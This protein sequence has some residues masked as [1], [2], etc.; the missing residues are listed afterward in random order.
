MN[1]C[2]FLGHIFP[3]DP[4]QVISNFWVSLYALVKEGSWPKI[5][6][7]IPLNALFWVD[8]WL[9]QVTQPLC[10]CLTKKSRI[11]LLATSHVMARIS[12]H[13]AN[14]QFLRSLMGGRP[15]TRSLCLSAQARWS[16]GGLQVPDFRFRGDSEARRRLM[17]ASTEQATGGVEKTAAEEKPRVLE[18]GAAPFGNFP[19]YSRFHPP[20]QRL[21]LLPPELLRR[22]FPQSS[23]TRPILGLDVGC[24]SGVSAGG[25][26]RRRLNR[27]VGS[28]QVRWA[29]VLGVVLHLSQRSQNE[30]K[31][32]TFD[33]LPL[34]PNLRA[35]N[36]ISFRN[37]GEESF[38]NSFGV[39]APRLRTCSITAEAG[40]QGHSAWASGC[41]L[42]SNVAG[43]EGAA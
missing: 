42:L 25:G 15:Y 19:H 43:G 27:E 7:Q 35:P 31:G 14:P 8:R 2:K 18:P 17:A 36:T 13:N 20:E 30:F 22:L 21:R 10:A 26:I 24:N 29:F 41:C 16:P 5:D 12:P 6:F 40:G 37:Q 32:V 39:P 9:E 38:S 34:L 28:L 11:I 3:C 23:E 1:G 33:P 4:G